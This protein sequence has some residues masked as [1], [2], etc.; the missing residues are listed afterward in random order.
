MGRQ[1][2]SKVVQCGRLQSIVLVSD[3]S[4]LKAI[5]TYRSCP[6]KTQTCAE[7]A[8][9]MWCFFMLNFLAI[10]SSEQELLLYWMMLVM[11]SALVKVSWKIVQRQFITQFLQK[12]LRKFGC[13][14]RRCPETLHSK[15]SSFFDFCC[16]LVN[17]NHTIEVQRKLKKKIL[18]REVALHDTPTR[19]NMPHRGHGGR[20]HGWTSCASTPHNS[21]NNWH[22]YL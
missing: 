11:N 1:K 13:T 2:C 19:S 21:V 6:I 7:L 17:W 15:V 20:E 16:Q 18:T 14:V 4:H 22:L 5:L 3:S 12:K 10:F 8:D 9:F